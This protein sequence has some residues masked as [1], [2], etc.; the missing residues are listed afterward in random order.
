MKKQIVV[1]VLV[2]LASALTA[3]GQSKKIP[4]KVK[5]AI[6]KKVSE[7]K[8][9]GKKAEPAKERDPFLHSFYKDS[10]PSIPLDKDH[11]P[12]GI[13]V[14]GI[15]VPKNGKAIAIISIPGY[16]NSFFVK[17][18]SIVRLD[19]REISG[20]SRRIIK[21]SGT[22]NDVYLEIIEITASEVRLVQK[23]RPD[24][25]YSIR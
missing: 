8:A 2:C 4:E 12:K 11:L 7:K 14:S 23:Q 9:A 3:G 6:E 25:I 17:E 20:H 21:K 22:T 1:L 24:Q 10:D 13:S 19:G 15:I 18:K 16:K 5:K